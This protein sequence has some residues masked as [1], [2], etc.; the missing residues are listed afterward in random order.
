V[1]NSGRFFEANAE[2]TFAGQHGLQD[3]LKLGWRLVD[4]SIHWRDDNR[5][6]RGLTK[7][8]SATR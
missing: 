7:K 8:S 1:N 4:G 2:S 3:I 6:Q 5:V